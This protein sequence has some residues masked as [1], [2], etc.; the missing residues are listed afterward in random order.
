MS[1]ELSATKRALAALQSLQDKVD[2]L[3]RERDAL[4]AATHAPIAVVGMACRFPGGADTPE[5]FWELLKNGV[6]ASCEVPPA[7]W[8]VDA[9]FDPDPA[10]P[11]K[12]YVRRGGFLQS[13]D[14][15]DAGLFGIAPREAASIDPQQRLVLELAWEALENANLAIDRL[16]DQPVGVYVGIANFEYGAHLLWSGDAARI[17]AYAGTG[18][19]LGVAA[20]RLSYLMG[21]TGPSLIVDTA[22]SSSLVTTHLACQALRNGECDLALSAGVNL[23]FGPETFVN[24]CKA[25][26][27]APDGRC[28]TFDA[29]A[30]GYARGE[31]G[32]MVVLKRLADARR[33]GDRI[34]AVIHGSA[35]NQDGP[36]G[37]LT[38][39]NGPA[40]TRVI[41][42]ALAAAGLLPAQVGYVEAHGTGTALG[43]PIEARALAA[44]YGP[45]RAADDPLRVGSVKTNFGHLESAAGIAGLIKAILVVQHGQVPPHLHLTRPSPHI[46]WAELPLSVPT[47]LQAWDAAERY[48]GISSFS[49][50]GTNAHVVVGNAPSE[51][52]ATESASDC[53]PPV[54]TFA[55]LP[56]AARDA[57]ALDALAATWRVQ[58]AEPQAQLTKPQ[59][60]WRTLARSAALG[61]SALPQRAVV[62]ADSAAAAAQRLAGV[63]PQARAAAARPKIAFLFTGQGSQYLG[64][65]RA[66]YAAEPV[67]RA[68]LDECAELLRPWLP[69]PL[70]ELLHTGNDEAALNETALTQ[71]V[72]FAIEYALAQQWQAW[73]IRPDA[74][75]GH[76]VGEYAAACVA[77]VFTL[78]E[79]VRLIAE[80][81]RLMQTLCPPGAMVALP[82]DEEQA[83]RVIGLWAGEMAVATVNG[84]KNVVV[85]SDPLA[86][87]A[88]AEGLA[89][90][91]IDA[92]QL[93]VTRAFHSPLMA[94]MLQPFA[95]VAAGIY[96]RAPQV[97]IYSN[98]SGRRAGAEIATVDYWVRHVEAP[99]RFAEGMRALLDDGYRIFVEIGPKPTLCALGREIATVLDDE[100]VGAQCLWLP[101][102]RAG[103]PDAATML[104]SLGRLWMRGAVPDW[105]AVLGTGP[106]QARLP[107]Y[108]FQRLPYWIDWSTAA[109]AA[110]SPHAAHAHSLLGAPLDSPALGERV[111]FAGTLAA[112]GLLAHH[113]IFGSVVLPAA[114]HVE[115]ALAAADRALPPAPGTHLVV[116]EVAIEH[117]LVLS[118]AAPTATQLVLEDDGAFRL[119]GKGETGWQAHSA[120]RAGRA[121]SVDFPEMLDLAAWRAECARELAP[122]DYYRRAHAVGIE[123]GERFRALAALWRN[124]AGDRV[125]A[126]LRLPDGVPADGYHLHPVLLDAAFQMLGVPLLARG[127]PYLP[128]GLARL[129]LLRAPGTALWCALR[130]TRSEGPLVT[131][132]IELADDSGAVLARIGE[133]RFQH[134]SRAQ[135][136]RSLRFAH[137]DW[138]YRI[139]WEPQ[140]LDLPRA[141]WLPPPAAIPAALLPQMQAAARDAGWYAELWPALDRLVAAHARRALADVADVVPAQQRLAARLRAIAAAQNE[142]GPL[143]SSAALAA[144]IAAR[145][146]QAA[147]ELALVEQCGAGLADALAGRR[148]GLDVLFPDGD[149]GAAGRVYTD[150]PGAQAINGLLCA[151]V[152]TALAALPPDRA[153]R[154]LEIGAGTGGTTAHVLP[155]LPANCSEYAFT[156]VS[157]LFLAKARE[158]FAAY[159]FIDYRLLDIERDPAAQGFRPGYHLIVAANVLHATRD[160]QQTLAHASALLAPGGLLVLL[161]AQGPQPWLDISFGLTEGWWRFADSGLRPD[162]PLLDLPRWS[163]LLT[164]SGFAEVDVVSPDRA[165]AAVLRQAVVLARK[166]PAAEATQWLL[167]ADRGGVAAALAQSGLP[168]RVLA[169][170]API[171]AASLRAQPPFGG[172]LFARGLDAENPD[173]A[174][175]ACGALLALLQALPALELAQAPRLAV[176]TRDATQANPF[177]AP[178]WAMAQVAAAE[179]PE[180]AC[181]RIDLD[182]DFSAGAL[183]D[184]LAATGDDDAVALRGAKRHVPRLAALP[185]GEEPTIAVRP[186]ASIIITGGLGD[187]G[188]ATARW[189]VEAQGAR[190]LVLAARRGLAAADAATLEQVAAL[191]ALGATVDVVATDVSVAAQVAALVA[192]AE[193]DGPLGGVI[194]AAG[195]LDDGVLATL[196]RDR[197]GAV[198]APKLAGAWNLHRASAGRLL[199]F[200]I[201]YASL[202]GV[203]GPAA[204]ASHAA[205]N[206]GLDALARL[207]S[208]QGLP[209]MAI[210]WGAWAEIGQAARKQAADGLAQRGIDSLAPAAGLAVLQHLFAH[211]APQA[212]VAPIRWETFL[213]QAGAAPFFARWR[214]AKAQAGAS[215]ANATSAADWL[216]G[217]AGL[218][219]GERRARVLERVRQETAR[220]LGLTSPAS[221]DD[222][223]GFFDMGMDSLTAVELRNALQASFACS[224]PTT[225]LFKYPN[226][227]ALAGH[228]SSLLPGAESAAA[229]VPDSVAP[230]LTSGVA[231]VN[232][233]D[234]QTMSEDELAALIDAE[235]DGLTGGKP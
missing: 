220:V 29:S 86:A 173:G 229:T 134:A 157:P 102:L 79:A 111:V 83:R 198:L 2:R 138:L 84:P 56:L 137:M 200:F 217:L 81:G 53:V 192:A 32:G 40:Q 158:R 13:V 227:G 23:I 149:F 63:L 71:P 20:G 203:V 72:L 44:A 191:Q 171:D 9:V 133:L 174:E 144:D 207:R 206:A 33:D 27:L 78:P 25:G 93:R 70:V 143:P 108:P 165:A 5:A 176:L 201:L 96:Y 120:G 16:Y 118:D 7:R 146:P 69:R 195:V 88:L 43:D 223:A 215:T 231:A 121:T 107:N 212:I 148:T 183:L 160:L 6:D 211:P 45:E 154:V 34:L 213:A 22:C 190:R 140:A 129:D 1:T 222:A 119:F 161:E 208:A 189:L 210:D 164:D 156:D 196:S 52:G 142:L 14:G 50:A 85:A 115:M 169:A 128:V 167:L 152:A 132:D 127:E 218:P 188:L 10:A 37:G 112:A 147:A 26:M 35:V 89:A 116:E 28:K 106:R 232:A 12:T 57:A 153:L 168:C 87:E 117:A 24:F 202:A 150:S 74:L 130:V 90:A 230:T 91:G 46:P 123:H 219:A 110:P 109:S 204:Q 19:S 17:N 66:L 62:V 41:R 181:R 122:D 99:V 214:G 103:Q 38:V 77:G 175:A 125:L 101:S 178:L 197:F 182:A 67:F 68:A 51:D 136:Q 82:F 126:Q 185:Q 193:R 59:A 155:A 31:G 30:D 97:P 145:F 187:L 199:D 18:G 73:G 124:E 54:S 36:S 141:D 4:H 15:F 228:L 80:R 39:P 49:F 3:E 225:L 205:A 166:P 194:H 104:D 221:I 179:Y 65:G 61:R 92:K 162:Y 226:T 135:L 55:V 234:V 98:L 95:A 209:A 64:M 233:T 94:P 180:L 42:Q 48:A 172:I 75:L 163:S 114:G 184:E 60:D 216:A 8:N 76:S 58:L 105:E 113:R 131:A 159:P 235:L 186:E 151:A 21:F 47:N 100:S 11:G 170:D 177:Q 224:L 139:D